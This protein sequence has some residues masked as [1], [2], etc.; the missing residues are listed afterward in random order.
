MPASTLAACEVIATGG[1][2]AMRV[3]PAIA[4]PVPALSGAQLLSG[5][6]ALADVAQVGVTEFANLP[7]AYMDAEQWLALHHAV[8]SALSRDEIAGV[9]VSHGTDT[10]EETAWFLDLTVAGSKPVVVTGAQRN[11]S[12]ADSDGPLNLLDS[13]RVCVSGE[14]RSK[15]TMVVLNRQIHAARDVTKTHTSGVESFQSGSFGCLGTVDDDRIVFARSPA[16][17]QHLALTAAKLPRVDIVA[18]YGGADG[19]QVR[20]AVASGAQGIVV[21]ALGWGN[22]NVAMY[23][24]LKEAIGRGVWVVVSSRVPLGRVRPVY[25]FVGGGKTLHDAGAV[26]ADDLSPPK[27]RILL[28][29][30]LQTPRSQ[31]DIQRLFDR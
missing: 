25:G 17:R 2:I 1:T 22:V 28:M 10:L 30:A 19:S 14:A 29:L 3:D 7:S 4:A 15:G 13:V 6:P 8:A 16:R 23:E 26:F 11:A 21:Q 24:A 9:V 5:V 27:A 31:A 20:V 12:S 18:A